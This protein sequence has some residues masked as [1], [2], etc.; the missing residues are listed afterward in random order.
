MFS[1]YGKY[2]FRGLLIGAMV[3]LIYWYWQKSTKAEDG[4]LDLLDRLKR[5]ED[6][7]RKATQREETAVSS[8]IPT[9]DLTTIKGIGPTFASRLAQAGIH[10]KAQLKRLTVA[11]LAE[12]LKIQPWRAEN[13]LNEG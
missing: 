9:E 11:Q 7:L 2:F 5:T 6:A 4:A 8:E 10:T 12:I 3:C 13:I 1:K